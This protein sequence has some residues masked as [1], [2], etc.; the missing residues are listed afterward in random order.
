M[1]NE[2]SSDTGFAFNF[3][4][5][6]ATLVIRVGD[7]TG[8]L[9]YSK[10]LVTQGDLLA[11]VVYGLVILLLVRELCKSHPGVTQYWYAGDSGE[12]GTFG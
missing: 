9:L 5:D 1:R 3:Y 6:W 7:G 4:H 10:E 12:G 11:M 2:R 8:H